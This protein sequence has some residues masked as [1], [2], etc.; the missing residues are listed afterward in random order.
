LKTSSNP[1]KLHGEESTQ[2]PE[3]NSDKNTAN[4]LCG[5]FIK[6]LTKDLIHTVSDRVEY[7]C[8]GYQEDCCDY[9]DVSVSQGEPTQF[10]L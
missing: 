1:E 6:Y 7:K 2:N 9:E 4:L 3:H 5:F 8:K 10:V